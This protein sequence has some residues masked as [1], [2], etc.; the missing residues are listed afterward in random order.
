MRIC[1]D[2]DGVI[3]AIKAP[4]ETYADVKPIKGAIEK[5]KSLKASGHY[6]IINTARHMKTTDSNLGLLNAKVTKLTLDWL[7]KNN[8]P[9]DEIYFGKPWAHLY[10]DVNAYRFNNWG[11]ISHDGSSLPGYSGQK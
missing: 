10:I 4:N 9:F 1:L 6:I 2:L 3:C 11:D 5:I 8:V 7:E